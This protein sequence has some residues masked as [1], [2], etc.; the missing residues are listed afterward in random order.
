MDIWQDIEAKVNSDN[1]VPVVKTSNKVGDL[2]LPIFELNACHVRRVNVGCFIT[3]ISGNHV[4]L[5]RT[6]ES[7]TTT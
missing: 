2:S 7:S 4:Y 6:Q 3:C 5:E 1:D